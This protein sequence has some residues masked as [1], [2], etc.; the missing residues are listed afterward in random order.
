MARNLGGLKMIYKIWNKQ[1]PINGKE[2]SYFLNK[3]P[4]KSETGD[5]ILIYNGE[6]VSQV[7]CKNI[8]ASVYGIDKTLPLDDFMVEYEKVLNP[9]IEE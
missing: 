4:F 7:E 2:A 8:L 1:E 6:R 3:E 9:E 5:I